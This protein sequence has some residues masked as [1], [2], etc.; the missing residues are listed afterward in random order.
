MIPSTIVTEIDPCM[1][2][3]GCCQTVAPHVLSVV[4]TLPIY[5]SRP[6]QTRATAALITVPSAAIGWRP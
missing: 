6:Q 1:N 5:W 3:L 2:V 4:R